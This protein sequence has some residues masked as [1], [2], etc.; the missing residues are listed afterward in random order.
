[1][2]YPD[3]ETLIK[4][5]QLTYWVIDRQTQGITHAESVIQ[6]PVRGNC[7][8]W[9][10]G[11]ILMQRDL[12]LQL[13]DEAPIWDKSKSDRYRRGSEPVTNAADGLPFDGMMANL[14]LSQER[15][16]RGLKAISPD[17]LTR[18]GELN[19]E[20]DQIGTLIAGLHWHETYHTGQLELLRQFTGKN[21]KVI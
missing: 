3:A 15:I 6:P 9:V 20:H 13:L 12:V 14:A 7:M 21:D 2:I 8:N 11:H 4:P 16:E 10:I 18:Q 19:G 1:M 17:S 5:F